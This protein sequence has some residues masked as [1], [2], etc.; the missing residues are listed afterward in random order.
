[1]PNVLYAGLRNPERDLSIINALAGKSISE[2]AEHL[3]L[4]PSTVRAAQRRMA[5]LATFNLT[6][7]GGG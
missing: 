3:A 5:D 2:V 6:L 4:A 7:T 1:M